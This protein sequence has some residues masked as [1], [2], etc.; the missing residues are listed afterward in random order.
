LPIDTVRVLLDADSESKL[1]E[2]PE[3]LKN[4][5]YMMAGSCLS[6]PAKIASTAKSWG[7]CSC[8]S[9][10]VSFYKGVSFKFEEDNYKIAIDN[11]QIGDQ[12][13]QETVSTGLLVVS[14]GKFINGGAMFNPYSVVNDGLIDITWVHDPAYA[15]Y[16]GMSGLMKKASS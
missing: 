4:C 2:G 3:R 5:R 10:L 15:G 12:R 7:F 14:N 9:S 16:W 8:A 1:P 11:L 13:G 6:M